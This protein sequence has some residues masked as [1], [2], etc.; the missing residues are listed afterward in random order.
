MALLLS[1]VVIRDT[2][3]YTDRYG[4]RYDYCRTLEI[5]G[6]GIPYEGLAHELRPSVLFSSSLDVHAYIYYYTTILMKR[7]NVPPR[8]RLLLFLTASVGW[9]LFETYGWRTTPISIMD[10]VANTF[11]FAV[12]EF[13]GERVKLVLGLQ[14]MRDYPEDWL[15]RGAVNDGSP[16]YMFMGR[17]NTNY[18][19]RTLYLRLNLGRS[20]VKVGYN[21]G[22]SYGRVYMY[23]HPY[24]T[25]GIP[26]LYVSTDPPPVYVGRVPMPPVATRCVPG[27]FWCVWALSTFLEVSVRY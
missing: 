15:L 21:L 6:W 13:G 2:C 1:F 12:G 14:P 3:L 4:V 11:G 8:Y 16:A 24:D 10:L 25:S 5:G 26:S 9:E 7:M 18:S 23:Y 27:S 17:F 19:P 20:T 22:A